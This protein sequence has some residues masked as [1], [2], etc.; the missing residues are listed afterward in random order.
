MGSKGV[1]CRKEEG[2]KARLRREPHLSSGEKSAFGRLP[3]PTT[4]PAVVSDV[5][6]RAK[7]S[8]AQAEPCCAFY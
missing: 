1:L 7:A 5:W 6:A 4:Y 3:I 8:V 2:A